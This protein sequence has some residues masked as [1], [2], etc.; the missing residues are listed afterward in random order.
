M[1]ANPNPGLGTRIALVVGNAEYVSARPLRNTNADANGV[2]D[3]LIKLGFCSHPGDSLT[4]LRAFHNLKLIEMKRQLADFSEAA[5]GADMAVIYYSGHGIEVDFRNYLIPVDAE[6]NHVRRLNFETISL[7]EVISATEGATGL[8]LVI[9]DACRDN[10]FLT[11]M[12]G[13]DLGKTVRNGLWAPDSSIS[14]LTFYAAKEGQIAR[15]GPVGGMSPFAGAL[16]TRL[17]E[18]G[19]ELMRIFGKVTEDV[20]RAT[21]NAQEPRLYGPP[22]SEEIF[23]SPSAEKV[24][25][26]ADTSKPFKA[27]G[28]IRAVE[29]TINTIHITTDATASHK[30]VSA[31]PIISTRFAN[32]AGVVGGLIIAVAAG[33]TVTREVKDWLK[34]TT[35]SERVLS[36]PQDVVEITS[37]QHIFERF[38]DSILNVTSPR[39]GTAFL[40][41]TEGYA[42]TTSTVFNERIADVRVS[43][44]L[45]DRQRTVYQP[46][47]I[48]SLEAKFRV[49]LF[50]LTVFPFRTDKGVE[51]SRDHQV[52]VG[53]RMTILGYGGGVQR[54]I[55][56][57]ISSLNGPRGTLVII[58]SLTGEQL[59][60]P[61]FNSKGKVVAV[62]S[63]VNESG[64][65]LA[66]PIRFLDTLLNIAGAR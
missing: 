52:T 20:R 40:V 26:E 3:T 35:S 32:I 23:L 42:L 54:A 39:T 63:D 5:Q 60:S 24:G 59:G 14:A 48:E 46:E 10:P 49:A 22:L 27:S 21:G 65:V 6:L 18:P 8:R 28:N 25:G 55:A 37:R 9:L 15:E 41:G 12:K 45:E 2:A 47:L 62:I 64:P 17:A 38:K 36:I 61:L 53:E 1:N 19:R 4:P 33:L 51:I 43:G 50:K 34:P 57:E 56:A 44:S 16:C 30:Q 31:N 58:A 29:N 7:N 11:R 13:L 66:V